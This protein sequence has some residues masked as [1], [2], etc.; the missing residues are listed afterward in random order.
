MRRRY[1]TAM[2]A[3][4][5][6][7][8]TTMMMGCSNKSNN[9]ES[10]SN[11]NVTNSSAETASEATNGSETN[12]ESYEGKTIAYVPKQLGNPYFGAIKDAIDQE[13]TANGF[14]FV[15]NA[16]DSSTDVDKQISICDAYISDGVD[17]L[18]L[19]ANDSSALK[20]VTDRAMAANIAV[21]TVDSG[22]DGDNYIS[23]IGTNNY[24][25]GC[26]AAKWFGENVK[27]QVAVIDGAGGNKATTDRFNGFMDTIK[28]YPN[29][30]VVTSDYGN[31]DMATSMTVAENFLTAY[32]D[33][34]AIFCCDDIMAQGAGQAVEA[35]GKGDD[36]II[37]GFDGSPEGAQAIIDG[38]MDASIAQTPA[39]MGKLAVD[40][41]IDHLNGK[42]VEHTIYTECE[43]V[44]KDNASSYLN[45]H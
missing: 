2:M 7:L 8:T 32:K 23:Y 43:I 12:A 19:T 37:C 14:T 45:W 16:P 41:A 44:T 11:A 34:S 35:A 3:L 20:D 29:I 1:F 17:V 33:L 26:L 39:K 40:Y 42:E 10:S 22:V 6:V 30:E 31:G 9:E 13:A 4:S 15:C 38:T 36:V 18:I 24:D 27:G 21:F 25:G 28:N 5:I